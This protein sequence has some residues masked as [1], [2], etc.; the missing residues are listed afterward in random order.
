[1]SSSIEDVTSDRFNS[2][3]NI[4]RFF[5]TWSFHYKINFYYPKYL[6]RRKGETV[7]TPLDKDGRSPDLYD[8]TRQGMTA[9]TRH[10]AVVFFVF[11][12]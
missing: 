9:S 2:L 12:N 10:L 7:S 6:C 11:L 8:N 3:T 5:S 1:M 4:H